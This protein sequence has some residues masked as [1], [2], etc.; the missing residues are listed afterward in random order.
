[1]SVLE[2]VGRPPRP[3]GLRPGTA[4]LRLLNPRYASLPAAFLRQPARILDAGCG[5]RE[6]LI[7]RRLFLGCWFEGIDIAD[8]PPG[9]PEQRAFDR[10]HQVDLDQTDLSFVPDAGFDYVICSHTIEHLED[11]IA[12][13]ARLCAKVRPGGR[14]YLEW[15]SVE[16]QAFPLRGFGLNFF[17]D[18][19][20][21]Q[22]FSLETV[23]A[24]VE[25][26]GLVIRYAGRRRQAVRMLLAPV[27]AACHS[28]RRR[29]LTLYDFWDI[30]GSCYV[31]RAMKPLSAQV[32]PGHAE[33]PGE[34]GPL[35]RRDPPH[36]PASVQTARGNPH[37]T[38]V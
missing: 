8:L 17:D 7:A 26:N 16:S 10:Y 23:A 9:S 6:A 38:S 13:V 11:G 30:L 27:L 5:P 28:L 3:K 1:M 4:L 18:G 37:D 14:L 29:R 36:T 2:D 22:T 35:R 20:H 31:V 25:E 15:P 21:K 32:G 19:T 12:L 33:P 34:P 24:V